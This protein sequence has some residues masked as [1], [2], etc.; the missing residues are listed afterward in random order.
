MN[1]NRNT[2]I[3]VVMLDHSRS[4]MFIYKTTSDGKKRFYSNHNVI[5]AC[6]ASR[7]FPTLGEARKHIYREAIKSNWTY[8]PD[9][10]DLGI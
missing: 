5:G 2:D 10:N 3:Y 1:K 7:S 9:R 8:N 6:F 4:E